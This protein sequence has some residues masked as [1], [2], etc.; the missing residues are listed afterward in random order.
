MQKFFGT[1]HNNLGLLLLLNL[2]MF[3]IEGQTNL[4]FVENLQK[5]KWANSPKQKKPKDYD[6][7]RHIFPLL[8]KETMYTTQKPWIFKCKWTKIFASV[9]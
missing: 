6:F 1:L 5:T 8:F 3:E 2:N 4:L 7:K 9:R